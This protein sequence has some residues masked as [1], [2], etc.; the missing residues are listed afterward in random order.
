[1]LTWAPYPPGGDHFEQ[2]HRCER[3]VENVGEYQPCVLEELSQAARR[4]AR[5][6]FDHCRAGGEQ[7]QDGVEERR[8]QTTS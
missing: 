5:A 6:A 8:T 7:G 1:M 4:P 2:D 3:D